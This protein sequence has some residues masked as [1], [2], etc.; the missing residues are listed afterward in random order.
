MTASPLPV[1]DTTNFGFLARYDGVLVRVA[2]LAERYFPDDPVT[3]LMKLRQFG[4]ILAQQIAARAAVFSSADEP[5]A[6]LLRRLR[7]EAGYPREVIDLFHDLRRLGN[8]AVHHHAGDHSAALTALKVARQLAVWFHRTFGEHGFKPGPFQPPR[9]PADPTPALQAEIE[10]LRAE[11]DAG[12]TEAEAARQRAQEAEAARLS[13]E[14]RAQDIAEERAFWERYAADTEATQAALAGRLEALQAAAAGAP[15]LQAEQKAA[16]DQAAQGIDLDE[17]ATRAIID[18]RLRA[19]GWEADT[20]ALRHATGARPVKGRNLA[21]AEW[22]TASG[23][24]DYALFTGTVCVGVVEAK[25]KRKNISAAVDQAGRYSQGFLAEPG[26]DLA[27]GSPWPS[28]SQ[29]AN[30]APYR[31]PF[32]FATNGRPYLKQIETQSGIWFRD[33]RQPTNLRRAMSD[34]LTPE[35]LTALLGMD[36]AQAQADLAALPFDFGFP[37]RDY[38]QRA[39]QAV[40]GAL[41]E[42]GRRAML[43]AMAT[44]TGK[45]RLAIAMLYRLLATKRFRRVCFVVD[46][47][48]LGDQAAGEFKTTRI[49]GPRTFAEIF[50]LKELGEVAPDPATKV[51]ICTIQSLVKRVLFPSEPEDVPPVDQY[52]LIVVDECHRGYLLDREMSDAELVFR[53]HEDYVSKY[54]RVL[55]HFDA[56][57]IG[58]TATPA[59]HTTDIFGVPIFTYAYREAV[60]DGWL[61]DHE[62]PL[63]IETELSRSG[64]TFKRGDQLTLLNPRT[65]DLDAAQAPDDL[66]FEVEDFNRRVVTREFNRVIAEEI[67]K[68]IDPSLPGKTLVFAATDGHADILVD[69]LKKAFEARYG[70]VDDAAVMK[71]TGSID[72]P[73]KAIRRFRND[74]NPKVAV[75]VDLLTT[76]VDVPSIT[77][78]VFVRRVA[79]RIL[80]EQMLG[81]ATRRCDDIGKETFR[82]FDAVGLYDALKDVTAM[83]PVVVNPSLTLTQL[84]QELAT[85]TDPAHRAVIRDQILVKLRRRIGKLHPAAAEQYTAAAGETPEDTLRRITNAPIEDLAA[86]V[87]AR[88]ALGPI[89]DWNPD[90]GRAVPLV[91]SD[92]QDRHVATIAGYG[93]AEKPEDYL[94]AFADFIAK[95]QNLIAAL[96]V[97]TQRPRDLTRQALRELAMAL[98]H[99]GFSEAKLRAAW[100]DAKNEEVAAT[101]AGFV[102]QA[103]LGDALE[104]WPDRVQRAVARILK[105][106]AW[107]QPQRQWLDRIARRVAELGVADRTALD[108]EQFRV[109]GGFNRINKVFDGRL[110]SILADINDEAWKKAG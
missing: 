48:A 47:S 86:W 14:Q 58:L 39:I 69:E 64:I 108:E 4:E 46:R 78:L 6:D 71:I 17:A 2:A 35:G 34:W 26:I 89:L 24:A 96:Q 70:A 79:S 68:H 42:D 21:I 94:T 56:V 106:Q 25:R 103:A 38:Q 41:A 102:R 87:K 12:L 8:D 29:A 107:T 100:R 23:P 36:R 3:A 49:V 51:H 110:D 101:I 83:K 61:I 44:G 90:A 84:L 73:G 1:P 62:P 43:L 30:A 60:V 95:N 19:R 28:E 45:T 105:R 5:Q 81:R 57:K 15:G 82:I 76:G 98:D 74:T 53:G 54:R 16:A 77:S 32:L 72:A 85:V 91:V 50:G 9:A 99:E 18:A 104:P 109:A 27:P 92:H 80:Y 40:E 52:D 10:R 75:T 33:A 37:L 11:R 93:R 22:P 59:L 88:P 97:V 31:L 63:R 55:E 20:Q 65:G 7:T 67:A 66:G 13:A